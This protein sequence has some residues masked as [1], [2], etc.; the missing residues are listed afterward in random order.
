MLNRISA[1]FLIFVVCLVFEGAHY[2][3]DL[4]QRCPFLQNP[5]PVDT[6]TANTPTSVVAHVVSDD[7]VSRIMQ[8][9]VLGQEVDLEAT[10]ILPRIHVSL[11]SR[12]DCTAS[13]GSLSAGGPNSQV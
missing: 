7:V 12:S 4:P 5:M 8:D 1:G 10:K 11:G 9:L 2:S 13:D 3:V 6:A